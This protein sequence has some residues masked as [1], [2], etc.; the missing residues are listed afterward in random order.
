MIRYEP[1]CSNEMTPLHY[2]NLI[3]HSYIYNISQTA[4]KEK[5][6]ETWLLRHARHNQP[7]CCATIITA[8]L[9]NKTNKS[10]LYRQ[11][12]AT[13]GSAGGRHDC[14]AWG[15]HVNQTKIDFQHSVAS[16]SPGDSRSASVNSPINPNHAKVNRA[17]ISLRVYYCINT[18]S[19]LCLGRR[20][21]FEGSITLAAAFGAAII[22]VASWLSGF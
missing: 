10:G 5:W 11:R 21:I 14:K 6:T 3:T 4:N 18:T 19:T 8:T 15:A 7:T 16:W 12:R 22:I 13:K 9:W 17:I 1:W 20:V 2:L